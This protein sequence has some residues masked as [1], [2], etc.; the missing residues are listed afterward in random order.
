VEDKLKTKFLEI[1]RAISNVKS[2]MAKITV[3]TKEVQKKVAQS[4]AQSVANGG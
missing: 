1:D 3:S 4:I 2:E